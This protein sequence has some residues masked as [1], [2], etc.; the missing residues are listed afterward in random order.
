MK[1]RSEKSAPIRTAGMT[2]AGKRLVRALG[3]VL[4]DVKGE[5]PLPVVAAVPARLDVKRVRRKTGLS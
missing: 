1:G 3:E 2:K 5:K 4:A